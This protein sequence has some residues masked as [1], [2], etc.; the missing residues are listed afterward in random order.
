MAASTLSVPALGADF[1]VAIPSVVAAPTVA[2]LAGV[3]SMVEAV[4]AAGMVA[5]I[6]ERRAE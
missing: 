4:L 5:A 3:A 6:A 1:R 2:G